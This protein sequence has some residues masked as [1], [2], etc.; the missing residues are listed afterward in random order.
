MVTLAGISISVN[1]VNINDVAPIVVNV[2]G[3]IIP[4]RFWHPPN[5]P[6][7][8]A[9]TV[10]PSNSLGI[11]TVPLILVSVHPTIHVSPSSLTTY[12]I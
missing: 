2:S 5:P 3:K 7:A 9:V 10:N 6:G 8:I 12:V 11:S 1:P 4:V